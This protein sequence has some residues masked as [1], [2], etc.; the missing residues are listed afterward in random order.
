MVR[1]GIRGAVIA[2]VCGSAVATAMG[3]LSKSAASSGGFAKDEASQR[4]RF[5]Y[6][7]SGTV[8]LRPSVKTIP[9][10]GVGSSGFVPLPAFMTADASRPVGAPSAALAAAES[11]GGA[12]VAKASPATLAALNASSPG[13]T[14][15]NRGASYGYNASSGQNGLAIDLA[16]TSG[17]VTRARLGSNAEFARSPISRGG[18]GGVPKELF[19][20]SDEAPATDSN[21]GEVNS[22][23]PTTAQNTGGVFGP[24]APVSQ[25]PQSVVQGTSTAGGDTSPGPSSNAAAVPA[26]GAGALLGLAGAALLRRKR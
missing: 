22:T 18:S 20:A 7:N 13:P 9:S 16:T 12:K 15:S 1:H 11:M 21:P 26:P 19:G 24:A 25:V 14:S 2:L 17:E 10:S 3:V 8:S 6:E 5:D 4:V 23:V